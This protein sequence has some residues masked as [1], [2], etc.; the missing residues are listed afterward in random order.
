M[1][2]QHNSKHSVAA[3]AAGLTCLLAF[4]VQA[5]VPPWTPAGSPVLKDRNETPE[6]H[7]ARMAWWREA[8]CGMFIHWSL[9]SQLGGEWKGKMSGGGYA[10]WIMYNEKISIADYAAVA[11]DFNPVKYDAEKWVMAAKN[12]GMKYMVITAKHHD[13]FAMFKSAASPFNI[14]DATPF[15]RDP[16]KELD[17]ACR[18]H[19]MKRDNG[20]KSTPELLRNL[21]KI[22][23]KG[24]N[25]LL[26]V[27][28]D[29]Q[30]RFEK[31]SVKVLAEV[32]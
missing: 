5:A 30:G 19:D 6:Q 24:G 15:K 18:K 16:L 1:K 21:C 11:K 32:G 31:A 12:A 25:Y 26:D 3:M 22:V 20:W 2:K 23:S 4:T 10:E 8:K 27:G 29:R 7:D 9:F 14:V 13:G 28:P 17:D